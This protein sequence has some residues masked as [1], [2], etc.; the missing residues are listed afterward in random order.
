MICNLKRIADFVDIVPI[1]TEITKYHMIVMT[2]LQ[3]EEDAVLIIFMQTLHLQA[4]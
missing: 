2:I 4:T 1:N 3:S